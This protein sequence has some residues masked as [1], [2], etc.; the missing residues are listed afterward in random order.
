M[1]ERCQNKDRV[2]FK[3]GSACYLRVGRG[4]FSIDDETYERQ[5]RSIGKPVEVF[6]E[7]FAGDYRGSK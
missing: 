7:K 3:I 5:I 4:L 6:D 2:A 1:I